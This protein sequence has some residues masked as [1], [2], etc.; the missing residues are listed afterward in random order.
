MGFLF[1]AF[2]GQPGLDGQPGLPGLPG[3][4]GYPGSQG[5]AG[6][7]FKGEQGEA[8]NLKYLMT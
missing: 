3:S 8:G 1:V 4:D 5:P 6:F 2:P 7:S